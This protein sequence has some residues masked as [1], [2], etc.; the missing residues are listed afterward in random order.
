[1][2]VGWLGPTVWMEWLTC[3]PAPLPT[4]DGHVR[5]EGANGG[6]DDVA[7]DVRRVED[8]GDQAD[9]RLNVGVHDRGACVRKEWTRGL[10]SPS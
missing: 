2:T 10:S 9:A 3:G 7:D 1:M 8:R 4:D 5:R 6:R